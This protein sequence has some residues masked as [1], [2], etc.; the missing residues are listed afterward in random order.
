MLKLSIV[1]PVYN[2][3]KYISRCLESIVS[4]DTKHR[5]EV[6]LID[7]GSSDNT[8]EICDE[9]TQRYRYIKTIHKQNEGVSVARN[10]GI[11]MAQGEY[12]T[13]VDSDDW[14]TSDYVETILTQINGRDL[15][16]FSHNRFGGDGH[17]IEQCHP[18]RDCVGILETENFLLHLKAEQYE[19]FGFTWNK[20]F[21]TDIIRNNN[22]RF[23]PGLN[24]REDEVFTNTY[25]RN[26]SSV[27]FLQERLYFYRELSTGLTYSLKRTKDWMLLCQKLDESTDGIF[28]KNLLY[29]EKNRI[30]KF[31][32]NYIEHP[33]WIEFKTIYDFYHRIFV[34]NNIETE[35][36]SAILLKAPCFLSYIL[37]CILRIIRR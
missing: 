21:R 13:F 17:I 15:L 33:S 30:M 12:I 18:Y 25:C 27:K 4:Q 19:C 20:C 8:S 2:A 32:L 35:C 10:V 37:Y 16:F 36:Q 34:S 26:I 1:I 5:Y 24:V 9:Y 7:D 14:V 6:L 11:E 3:D 31:Y 23:I 29:W 28:N 22:I